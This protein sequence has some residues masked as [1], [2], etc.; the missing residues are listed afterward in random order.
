MVR[1]PEGSRRY[2]AARSATPV[3]IQ[4]PLE[5][6]QIFLEE[7]ANGGAMAS[8]PQFLEIPYGFGHSICKPWARG[9]RA[10]NPQG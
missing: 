2:V 4:T 5:F 9:Y 7:G 3:T 10:G 8:Q 1:L 6:I